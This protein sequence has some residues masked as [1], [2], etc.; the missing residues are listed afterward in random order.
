MLLLRI[1]NSTAAQLDLGTVNQCL[2]AIT[3]YERKYQIPKNLLHAISV[4]ESGRWDDKAKRALPWP[5]SVNVDGAPYYFD[6]HQ[7]AATFIKQKL[8]QGNV[9]NIDIGCNQISWQYHGHHFT[10]PEQAL[11]PTHNARYAASFLHQHY[12]DTKDWVKATGRYHSRTDNLAIAYSDRVYQTWRGKLLGNSV[13]IHA[14]N[15]ATHHNPYHQ[16]YNPYYAR[17]YGGV[18]MVSSDTK[19]QTSERRSPSMNQQLQ[20]VAGI[21]HRVIAQD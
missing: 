16:Y 4:V 19:S 17:R 3:Y 15:R 13:L 10:S 20:R 1:E 14:K 6:T 7:Q 12:L 11:N 21:T 8:S 5:W 2:N 18:T 9:G